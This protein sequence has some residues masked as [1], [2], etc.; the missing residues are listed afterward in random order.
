MITSHSF[1]KSSSWCEFRA[2]CDLYLSRER[3][4]KF[5]RL[6]MKHPRRQGG[7]LLCLLRREFRGFHQPVKVWAVSRQR[8]S[9]TA[10][11][12]SVERDLGELEQLES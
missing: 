5:H 4:G 6:I 2:G 3:L 1:E 8:H 10:L 9:V 12:L 7:V 11:L